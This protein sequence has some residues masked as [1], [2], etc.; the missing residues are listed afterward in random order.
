MVV[1]CWILIYIF[2]WF[3]KPKH[4]PWKSILTSK[5]F[6]S[7][8]LINFSHA[9]ALF[10]MINEM[11]AYMGKVLNFDIKSVRIKKE[12]ALV[13]AFLNTFALILCNCLLCCVTAVLCNS[14]WLPWNFCRLKYVTHLNTSAQLLTYTNNFCKK[15]FKCIIKTTSLVANIYYT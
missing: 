6:L 1:G 11:P 14:L 9:W 4:I 3:Q 15:C 2:L 8:M 5:A 13:I 10:T 7:V 12:Q